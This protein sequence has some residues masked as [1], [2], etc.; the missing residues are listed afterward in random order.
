MDGIDYITKV[1]K[2]N[3]CYTIFLPEGKHTVE[4]TGG[5]AFSNS[6]NVTSLWSSNGIAI[7]GSLA[8]LLLAALYLFLKIKKR[9]YST[10]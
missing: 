9:K 1:M 4:L 6:I 2:G 5:N 10:V 8:V 7:F 3:D